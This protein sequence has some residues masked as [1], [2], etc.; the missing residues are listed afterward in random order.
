MIF[1]VKWGF[2]CTMGG[3]E[4]ELTT[5]QAMCLASRENGGQA[6]ILSGGYDAVRAEVHLQSGAA[7]LIAFGRPFI[8]NP[9]LVERMR[10]GKAWAVPPGY[11]L[12]LI[13]AGRRRGAFL[14]RLPGSPL[15]RIGISH[16]CFANWTLLLFRT[17]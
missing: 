14:Q 7:E 6:V 11:L 9:D 8:A 10:S 4:P 17:V 16:S 5:V 12:H 13:G 2:G 3:P 15:R 1:Y